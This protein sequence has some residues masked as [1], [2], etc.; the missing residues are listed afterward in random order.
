MSITLGNRVT[1]DNDTQMYEL[2]GSMLVY[3]PGGFVFNPFPTAV[4]GTLTVVGPDGTPRSTPISYDL[5]ARD[6]PWHIRDDGDGAF[7]IFFLDAP[8]GD[9]TGA[10]ESYSADG[11]LLTSGSYEQIMGTL[12]LGNGV[13]L[14]ATA[15]ESLIIATDLSDGGLVGVAG[16]ATG[17]TDDYTLAF[18]S[19]EGALLNTTDFPVTAAP[20]SASAAGLPTF[21]I[22]TSNDTIVVLHQ[23]SKGTEPDTNGLD[24]E[25]FMHTFDLDGNA[26]LP[27]TQI[28]DNDLEQGR[29]G[30]FADIFIAQ[31]LADG[32]IAIAYR[33]QKTGVADG[34]DPPITSDENARHDVFLQIRNADG[35]V[36]V[37]EHLV[38]TEYLPGSQS[39]ISIH[40]FQDGS[41][42]VTFDTN[43]ISTADSVFQ[44]T[45]IIQLYDASGQKVGLNQELLVRNEF[46]QQSVILE[47]GTGLLGAFGRFDE[48]TVAVGDPLD[49]GDTPGVGGPQ[50]DSLTGSDEADSLQ[51]NG[52]NDT[53][54]GNGGSDTLEGGAGDDSLSGGTE[55]DTIFG[56]EGDDTADG[57]NGRDLVFLNQGQDL[58]IDNS[59]GGDLGRDTV[60]AGFGDD[61]IQGGNGNDEFHGEWGADLIFGRLGDDM[62]F[63][64]DQFDT[65]FAG[66]GADTVYGGNGRDEI[67]LNQGNDLFIDNA[68]GGELGRD[69]VFTGLGDDTVEGGNG[70]D[71]F[72]G[73]DGNDVINAR[74]GNDTV[75][76]GNNFDTI[77]AGEGNDV[78]FGGNGRDLIFLNQGDDL[79]ND[80]AQGGDLGR[81]HVF[82]GLGN[83]TIQG[84]NGD[85]TFLGEA[86]EDLIFARLGNDLVDGG[87]DA[88]TID[89]G[90][91]ADTITGGAGADVFIFA[92]GDAGTGVDAVTDFEL[93]TDTLRIA[94]ATAANTSV[95]VDAG[96]VLTVSVGGTALAEIT[97]TDDLSGYTVNDI[98][99]V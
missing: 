55:F 21:R 63:G 37:A 23:Y 98:D 73:E 54:L 70:D 20:A 36:A 80:N 19:S 8:L 7:T 69:T 65:I 41:F 29:L 82:S 57:G 44:N 38:N 33:V 66:E 95:S 89:G 90:A 32:R 99:F 51:G 52:G 27:E 68:Q 72:Y 61:T 26:L 31:T 83:D 62:I 24:R 48:I 1:F 87:A 12:D 28:T 91:G 6:F 88:D 3:D 77:S 10:Y 45:G 49:G 71:V 92:A 30:F 78:V 60:F 16:D 25:I 15:A 43:Y 4:P 42:A 39:G 67:Y 76:G 97:S 13:V 2:D 35:S 94:G 17:T 93:G 40:D 9:R 47:D 79:F 58:F 14:P 64:G 5:N 96:G 56:G 46:V 86:G 84:G 34:V 53:L 85:D 75:Y 11:T 81:D 18:Y 50:D 22:V 59:Q 74:L